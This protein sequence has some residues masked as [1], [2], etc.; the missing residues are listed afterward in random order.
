MSVETN[1]DA[2]LYAM[3]CHI[4]GLIIPVIAPLVI[5]LLKKDE[6]SFVK[7][8][9]KEAIN[10]QITCF[11]ASIIAG[12]LCIVI[13]GILILPLLSLA[14]LVFCIIAGIKS[15]DGENYRYPVCLRLIK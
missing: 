3:L 10:F 6:F 13:I 2:R 8:Q 5:W 11:I 4:L 1:K 14:Y 12:L 9:G 7:D 15:Y